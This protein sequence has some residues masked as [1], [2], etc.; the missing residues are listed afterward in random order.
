MIHEKL[1]NRI[2]H[3]ENIIMHYIYPLDTTYPLF[4]IV[5]TTFP[6]SLRDIDLDYEAQRCFLGHEYKTKF[7][8]NY[9]HGVS[10]K[11]L[12][13]AQKSGREIMEEEELL[14]KKYATQFLYPADKDNFTKYDELVF[15]CKAYR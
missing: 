11:Q 6:L 15:N 5:R 3:L 14:H 8:G 4:S 2:H 7:V 1:V 12:L 10:S 9:R 13:L